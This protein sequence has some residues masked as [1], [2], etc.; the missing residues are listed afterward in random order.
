MN[1]ALP[2][3]KIGSRLSPLSA[4]AFQ[5]ASF[6]MVA[7]ALLLPLLAFYMPLSEWHTNEENYFQLA[8]RRVAP[9]TFSPWS[10]VFDQSNARIVI[11]YLYG[12]LIL[13]LGYDAAHAVARVATAG[14]YAAGLGVMFASLRLS[15]VEAIAVVSGFHLLGEHILGGEWLFRGTEAKTLAYGLVFLA[16][17]LAQLGRWRAAFVATAAATWVHFLVGGFW[18]V[19]L[20]ISALVLMRDGWRRPI[21][22]FG[23]YLLLIAPLAVIVVRDQVALAMSAATWPDAGAVANLSSDQIYAWRNAHH[24]SPFV[25]PA[26]TSYWLRGM[27][28]LAAVVAVYLLLLRRRPSSALLALIVGFALTALVVALGVSYVDRDRMALAKLYLFRPS[29][30]TLLLFLVVLLMAVRSA[31]ALRDRL[32]LNVTLVIIAM[33]GLLFEIQRD[34]KNA[35]LLTGVPHQAD[36]IE[37]VKAA[38]EPNDV[39]L[40]DPSTDLS[41][42]VVRLNRLIE[43]PTVVT[44]K[45]VPTAPYDVLRWYALLQW[46]SR[47]F[48]QGCGQR[49]DAVPV[50]L[51]V[52]FSPNGRERIASCGP[53]I[54]QGGNTAL[55]RV[56]R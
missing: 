43:R 25:D 28:K 22:A 24:V 32:L 44:R 7:G 45:F 38:S 23:I 31:I 30:A 21:A 54:W 12:V 26:L 17:G 41:L 56:Q 14:L 37:A 1:R 36:L 5:S 2:G 15:V 29:S 20:G 11:E 16:I 10:A 18:A 39:V 51:L 6:P 35:T 19:A 49:D 42:A 13:G 3:V 4:Y 34:V 55:T 48:E 9:E 52:T 33:G 47:L 50:K 40:L 27:A 53:V 46:R 8:Y